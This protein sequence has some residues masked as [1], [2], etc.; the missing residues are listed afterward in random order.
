MTIY[1]L[2]RKRAHRLRDALAQRVP[3]SK[4]FRVRRSIA[5]RYLAGSGIELGALHAPLP[6][7]RG[8][9]VRYVDRMSVPDLRRQYPELEHLHLVHPDIIDDAERLGTVQDGSTDFVIANH[10][11]EHTEDPIGALGAWLRVV[12][13]GGILYLSVPNKLHTFDRGRPVTTLEHLVQ[14]HAQGPEGSRRA[15]Y[16]EWARLVDRKP[17]DEIP[18][19]VD[20]LLQ[21]AYSIHF[22]V[23]TEMEMLALVLHVGSQGASPFSIELVQ[24]NGIEY[25]L[26]LRRLASAEETE[27]A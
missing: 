27:P 13:P 16:E 11:L 4:Q 18:A 7:A 15:H 23:W 19:H 3:L 10:V 21:M 8:V 26:I 5:A 9:H 6:V 20:R 17:E 14:D 22:H 25:I 12:R 2:V 24:K 1:S